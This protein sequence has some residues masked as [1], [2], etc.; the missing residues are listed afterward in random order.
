[1][2]KHLTD[3]FK[4]QKL[5]TYLHHVFCMTA[6]TTLVIFVDFNNEKV[7]NSPKTVTI[8]LLKNRYC[9]LYHGDIPRSFE[10]VPFPHR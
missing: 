8:V 1:M 2:I 10:E 7:S 6:Q 5:K 3:F 4:C 9:E